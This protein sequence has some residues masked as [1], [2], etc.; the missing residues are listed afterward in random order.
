MSK[1]TWNEIGIV[2]KLEEKLKENGI[3][4]PTAV[5]A[6]TIPILLGGS[7]V[8]AR[9]QTGTGKT[10]AYLLPLLQ[11]L[12]ANSN[13][14]Q[15]VILSPTQELAMQILRVAEVYA[16][17][18]NL[19]VQQLIGGAGG[20]RAGGHRKQ[21]HNQEGGGPRPRGGRGERLDSVEKG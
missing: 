19:R 10:L 12:N 20:E 1:Q 7:D 3:V 9:S 4:E 5:Q 15:A 21:Q 14:L 8:S 11:R 16:E 17:P 18:L 13:A 2:N 6:E